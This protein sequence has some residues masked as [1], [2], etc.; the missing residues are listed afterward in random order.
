MHR[1]KRTSTVLERAQ[2]RAAGLHAINP[3]VDFGKSRSLSNL[4]HLM[5]QLRT[6]IDAYNMAVAILEKSNVE[7]QSLEKELG[8]LADQM[9]TSVAYTYGKD[10]SEYELVGGVRKSERIRR[11]VHARLKTPPAEPTGDF[12]PE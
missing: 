2:L 7:I 5:E 8:E 12:Q 9:L 11:S 4:T 6:K 1:K 3:N 10:S